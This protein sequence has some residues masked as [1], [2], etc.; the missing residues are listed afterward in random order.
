MPISMVQ[1]AC[2]NFPLYTFPV[3][4]AILLNTSPHS[5][6]FMTFLDDF[7]EAEPRKE[8][9]RPDRQRR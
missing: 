2:Y 1:Y 8:R 9:V 4:F 5:L 7:S 6:D 3:T